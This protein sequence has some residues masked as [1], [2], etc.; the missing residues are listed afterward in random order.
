MFQ[1]AI[2]LGSSTTRWRLTGHMH[3]QGATSCLPPNSAAQLELGGQKVGT[4]HECHRVCRSYRHTASASSP[5]TTTRLCEVPHSC[6]PPHRFWHLVS[7]PLYLYLSIS[8]PYLLYLLAL[9]PLPPGASWAEVLACCC[10]FEQLL[11]CSC[12][13][14][15]SLSYGLGHL[16]LTSA[17]L[18]HA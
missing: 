12:L 17:I 5:A 11:A 4:H 16:R 14:H 6:P 2:D 10:L 15:L 18:L 1:G 13:A 7:L 8:W 9:P 3:I